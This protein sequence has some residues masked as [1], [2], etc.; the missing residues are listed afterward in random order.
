MNGWVRR[1]SARA[2]SGEFWGPCRSIG[3]AYR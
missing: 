2:A 3:I 1:L